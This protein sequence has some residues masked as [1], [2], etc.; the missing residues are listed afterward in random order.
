LQENEISES[1][2]SFHY[3]M[4]IIFNKTLRKIKYNRIM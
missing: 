1:A 3:Y 2:I 4:E